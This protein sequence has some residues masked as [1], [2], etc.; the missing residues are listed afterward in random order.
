MGARLEHT[1]RKSL[2][3]VGQGTG[4]SECSARRAI[5]LLKLIVRPHKR[6]VMHARLADVFLLTGFIFAVGFCSLL[7]KVRSI[8]NLHSFVMKLGFICRD[9]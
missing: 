1:A 4:V 8:C 9:T 2:K 7:S 5:Q 6:T 3:R